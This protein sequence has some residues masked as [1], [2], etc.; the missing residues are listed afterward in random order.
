VTAYALAI[1]TVRCGASTLA[2]ASLHDTA[3]ALVL[4]CCLLLIINAA[5]ATTSIGGGA[6]DREVGII[7][8][9]HGEHRLARRAVR[10]WAGG[11]SRDMWHGANIRDIASGRAWAVDKRQI[12][13]PERAEVWKHNIIKTARMRDALLTRIDALLRAVGANENNRVTQQHGTAPPPRIKR[14]NAHRNKRIKAPSDRAHHESLV[15][16]VVG[17]R[18]GAGRVVEA[19]CGKVRIA[20][21]A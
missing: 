20:Y 1:R 13:A 7:K 18:G 16:Q 6:S 9:N 19:A 8:W 10:R 14:R 12:S 3:P 21:R 15:P 17:R 5:S 4:C 2:C 11:V